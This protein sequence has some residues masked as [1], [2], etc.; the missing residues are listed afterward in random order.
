MTTASFVPLSQLKPV[1]PIQGW[2]RFLQ[3]GTGYLKTARGAH[4]RRQD[5]FSPLILT[6]LIAMALE[7]FVMAA[8]MRQGKLPCNH[9]MRDL[10]EAMDEAFPGDI[11]NIREGLLQLDRY[12]EICDIDSYTIA[13]PDACMIPALLELAGEMQ[14]LV[15]RIIESDE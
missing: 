7:K 14:Q 2:G 13:P 1:V 4:A 15:T 3:D 9:T 8:L 11:A 10:V 5:V 6:N 12:Q